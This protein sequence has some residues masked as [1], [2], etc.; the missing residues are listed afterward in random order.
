MIKKILPLVFL[1]LLLAGCAATFTNLT[2]L[3]Q[4]RNANNL[5]TV[6]VAFTTRQQ[7]LQW[8]TINPQ[9]IVGK[10]FIPMHPTPLM[11]NRWEALI[12]VP[13]G[14]SE[15]RY[16]YKFDFQYNAFGP[17]KEDSAKSPAYRLRIVE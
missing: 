17:R 15:V 11:K 6:E 5:Y 8:E 16:Q 10:E 9:V 1:P 13:A 4:P 7:S 12:P 3:Q 14:K 2:S